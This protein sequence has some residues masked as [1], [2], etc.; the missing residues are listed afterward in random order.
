MLSFGKY[1][2]LK[3]SANEIWDL[4]TNDISVSDICKSLMQ[5]YDVDANTCMASVQD[6]LLQMHK[7]EFI[8]LQNN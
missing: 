8:E 5:V 4:I 1:F 7:N 2:L 6:F 3:G